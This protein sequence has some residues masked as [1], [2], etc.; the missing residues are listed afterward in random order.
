[1]FPVTDLLQVASYSD[2]NTGNYHPKSFLESLEHFLK[3]LSQSASLRQQNK[4]IK[5]IIRN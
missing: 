1:M 5:H 4:Q 2:I 3:S